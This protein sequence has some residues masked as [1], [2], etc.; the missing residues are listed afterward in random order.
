[1]NALHPTAQLTANRNN[2]SLFSKSKIMESLLL[3][4]KKLLNVNYCW[5]LVAGIPNYP[6][7]QWKT[8]FIFKHYY[9]KNSTFYIIFFKDLLEETQSDWGKQ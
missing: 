3:V 5:L 4:I 6:T 7:L 9:L 2:Y 8:K 1:M